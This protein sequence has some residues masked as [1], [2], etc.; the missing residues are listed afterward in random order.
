MNNRSFHEYSRRGNL[1]ESEYRARARVQLASTRISGATNRIFTVAIACDT[2]AWLFVRAPFIFSSGV[3]FSLVRCL[4]SWLK[5]HL[6]TWVAHMKAA[7]LI[8]QPGAVECRGR[9]WKVVFLLLLLCVRACILSC[10]YSAN[11]GLA[12]DPGAQWQSQLAT[13]D[14]LARPHIDDHSNSPVTQKPF[15]LW[16]SITSQR[17]IKY[18]KQTLLPTLAHL[19]PPAGP[20]PL[21]FYSLLYIM[22]VPATNSAQIAAKQR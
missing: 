7:H 2:I 22:A 3:S 1:T 17:K 11:T 16:A 13:G 14:K 10:I 18:K 4:F 20:L 15:E 6:L 19:A 9:N 8:P 12:G 5:M 21:N